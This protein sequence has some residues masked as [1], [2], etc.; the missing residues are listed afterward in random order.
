[1]DFENPH[2]NQEINPFFQ[3]NQNIPN[4][5]TVLVLGIISIPSCFCAIIGVVCGI[6]ALVLASGA[7]KIYNENPQLYSQSSYNNMNAGRICAIIGL[8]L[9]GLSIVGAIIHLIIY[10]SMMVNPWNQMHGL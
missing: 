9:S 4:A 2:S 10:G 6:I 7:K 3:Q 8:S 1:M 5:T